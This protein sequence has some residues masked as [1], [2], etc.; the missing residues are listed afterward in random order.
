MFDSAMNYI[1]RNSVLDYANGGDAR[2]SYRNL[3][4]LRENYPP[5]ALHAL[6]N[7]LS[8]HD[9]ARSLHVFGA[10]EGADAAAVA[11]AKQRLRLAL[12][13]MFS[14]PGAPA[15]FYGDEAGVTGGEDPFNRGTYPWADLGG[16]PDESL[17][18]YVSSLAKMRREHPV[19]SHG[20]LE[21]PLLLDEHV[22]V[23]LRREGGAWAVTAVN[24]AAEPKRVH[25]QLR[26]GAPAEFRDALSDA[27]QRPD[28]RGMIEF[29]VPP[30]S[31]VALVYDAL[32]AL[33]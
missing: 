1:F 18:A 2:A 19:L 26:A 17:R 13:F 30:M 24:N 28:G 27:R 20:A 12:F 23:L 11:L 7:L 29:E 4:L 16:T 14:Y 6:M 32:T 5:Q 25:V 31:G 8:S 21:A 10:K 3:E 22:V 15:I 9:T 33:R